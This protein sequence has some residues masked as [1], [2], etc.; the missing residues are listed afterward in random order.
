MQCFLDGEHRFAWRNHNKA[1]AL[2]CFHH[3]NMMISNHQHFRSLLVCVWFFVF[4]IALFTLRWISNEMNHINN[5][6]NLFHN[7][8]YKRRC[9]SLKWPFFQQ[10]K[11]KLANG[12]GMFSL[13][14]EPFELY[15][16][17]HGFRMLEMVKHCNKT[18]QWEILRLRAMK[19]A[20]KCMKS[21]LFRRS[22]NNP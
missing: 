6:F 1:F 3:P 21:E 9:E 10:N 19:C 11:D 17:V 12:S 4:D 7:Q 16:T 20:I 14:V 18:F 8:P 15:S 5:V 22:S 2:M 13:L